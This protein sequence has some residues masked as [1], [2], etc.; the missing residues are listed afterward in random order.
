[1]SMLHRIERYGGNYPDGAFVEASFKT[2]HRGY[3][4]C[5]VTSDGMKQFASE[6]PFET[7]RAS[8]QRQIKQTAAII[9]YFTFGAWPEALNAFDS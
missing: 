5:R 2:N 6:P 8:E 7:L 4:Q 1:M 3:W 9:F